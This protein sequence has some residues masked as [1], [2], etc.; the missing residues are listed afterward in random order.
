MNKNL[1]FNPFIPERFPDGTVKVLSVDNF[2][3][4]NNGVYNDQGWPMS[5]IGI[6]D[7]FSREH[8]SKEELEL[9]ASRLE[10]IR[11]AQ[12]DNSGKS[13]A[14]ILRE[15]RPSWVQTAAEELDYERYV[16]QYIDSANSTLE[17]PSEDVNST[18]D[19][20]GVDNSSGDSSES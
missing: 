1:D 16:L 6:L 14:Q 3:V 2:P 12:P 10:E 7:R 5:D 15:I 18:H 20:T 19:G 11:A 17:N 8:R 9:V 13:D 4:S